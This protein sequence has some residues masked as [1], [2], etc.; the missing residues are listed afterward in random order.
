M[1][2]NLYPGSDQ[3]SPTLHRSLSRIVGCQPKGLSGDYPRNPSSPNDG[4]RSGEQN[5]PSL[6]C[7]AH[8][9]SYVCSDRSKETSAMK[10][11]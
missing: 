9:V 7:D 4:V 5:A 2:E 11:K 1:T 8:T 10:V 6:K 3:N